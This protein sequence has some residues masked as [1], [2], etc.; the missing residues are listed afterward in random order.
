MSTCVRLQRLAG[1]S[2]RKQLGGATGH[3][4]LPRPMNGRELQP[5]DTGYQSL[6]RSTPVDARPA[7][8]VENETLTGNLMYSRPGVSPVRRHTAD[9]LT[10]MVRRND[11]GN[12]RATS[13]WSSYR[14]RHTL[15]TVGYISCSGILLMFYFTF[16]FIYFN[17]IDCRCQTAVILHQ[18]VCLS[19]YFCPQNFCRCKPLETA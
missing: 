10:Y 6:P 1:C 4:T 15:T 18:S 2:N 3:V 14:Y 9:N 17:L 11:V 7:A 16:N 12:Y 5:D 19:I 13:S 8:A